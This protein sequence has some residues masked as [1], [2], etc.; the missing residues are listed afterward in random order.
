MAHSLNSI[1][2]S[3]FLVTFATG[4]LRGN[5]S[6]GIQAYPPNVL[7]TQIRETKGRETHTHTHTR[8]REEERDNNSRQHRRRSQQRWRPSVTS[9]TMMHYLTHSRQLQT[10]PWPDTTRHEVYG[11][12]HAHPHCMAALCST[13]NRSTITFELRTQKYFI[14]LPVLLYVHFNLFFFTF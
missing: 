5:Y 11:I 6:G 3:S 10:A 8:R 7:S 13:Q 9:T 4:M 2:G 12:T 14:C 1:Y